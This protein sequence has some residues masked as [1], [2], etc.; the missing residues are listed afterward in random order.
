MFL[1]FSTP[2]Q[3]DPYRFRWR[4]R[5]LMWLALVF[6]MLLGV[7]SANTGTYPL[8][9]C[10]DRPPPPCFLHTTAIRIQ[11][12]DKYAGSVTVMLVRLRLLRVS[13][14]CY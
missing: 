6:Y 11:I 10:G 13:G 9:F 3:V 1:G 12:D 14:R 8:V 2:I 5:I 4:I 7:K